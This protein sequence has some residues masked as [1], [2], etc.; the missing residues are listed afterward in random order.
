MPGLFNP[1]EDNVP[2]GGAYGFRR[3]GDVYKVFPHYTTFKNGA[4][5]PLFFKYQDHLIPVETAEYY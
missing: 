1:V 4:P 5:Q 2:G 3:M